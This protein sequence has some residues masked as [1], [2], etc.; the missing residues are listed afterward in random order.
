MN[1]TSCG[2]P[3][4]RLTFITREVRGSLA[5]D[6]V[7]VYINVEDIETIYALTS[8]SIKLSCRVGR[9]LTMK[10]TSMPGEQ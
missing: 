1:I 3:L 10:L 9:K 4:L 5:E 6:R 2:K 8:P 7:F